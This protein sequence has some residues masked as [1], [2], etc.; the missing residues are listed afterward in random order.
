MSDKKKYKEDTRLMHM[1]RDPDEYFG[2]V[3]PPVARTSTILYDSLADFESDKPKYRYGN[4][5]TPMSDKFED[6]MAAIENGAGAVSVPTG[7]AAI[8]LPLLTY[9]KPG[10]HLLVT[11]SLY[12]PTRFFCTRRLEPMGVEV[13]YYDPMIGAGIESLLRENTKAIFMESPG[14]ATY[15]V[16]DVPAI[17]AAARKHDVLTMIDNSYSGGILFKPLDHGVN[18][19]LSAATKYVGGHADVNLGVVVS[20]TRQ[21]D[22]EIRQCSWDLGMNASQD[23]I[24]LALRGLRTMKLRMEKSASS[25]AKVIE[26]L[27]GR[28]EVQK[29]FYPALESHAG[30]EIWKRDFIGANGVFSFQL[31]PCSK[32]ALHGFVDALDLFPVGSSWGGYESLLQPQNLKQCRSVK[33]WSEEG[34]VLRLQIGLEDPEDLIADLDQAFVVF[35]GA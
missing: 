27:Q 7:M 25:A 18:I 23:D 26:Y 34:A 29:I 16:Q 31:Q 9:I 10:D 28:D 4:L 24:Y 22:Q 33:P 3:N 17:V 1:G 13:E 35:N 2:F 20:D 8:T 14:S 12:E 5:G 19:S 30:H 21:R 11:D 32:Q 15:E 6:A